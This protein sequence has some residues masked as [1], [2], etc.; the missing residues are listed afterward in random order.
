MSEFLLEWG[1]E[2]LLVKEMP[3][4]WESERLSCAWT[5]PLALGWEME[6]AKLSLCGV[7]DVFA[8]ESAWAS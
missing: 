7:S 5:S 6:S 4:V 3:S 1:T 2:S 8:R